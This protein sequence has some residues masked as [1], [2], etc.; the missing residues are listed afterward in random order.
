[1]PPVLAAITYRERSM[2]GIGNHN[3][4]VAPHLSFADLT[5]RCGLW[6]DSFNLVRLQLVEGEELRSMAL[7]QSLQTTSLSA[8][9][10][11]IYDCNG[12]VLAE[13]ASVWTVALEPAYIEDNETRRKLAKGLSEILDMDEEEIYALTKKDTYFTYVKRKVETSVRDEINEFLE[14]EEIKRGVQLI[15]DYKRYYPYGDFFVPD[16]GLYRYRQ[17]GAVRSGNPVR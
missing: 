13:S 16:P 2:H 9:R 14:E 11:T 7:D 3:P 1:M 4:H 17:P 15:E 8:Q 10:G 5:D 6:V 12:N